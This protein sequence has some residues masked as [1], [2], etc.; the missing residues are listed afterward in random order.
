MNNDKKCKEQKCASTFGCVM[1]GLVSGVA[2]GAVGALLLSSN[3]KK[4]KK[5]ADKM[6]SAMS[7]LGESAMEMFK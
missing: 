5:K 7:E 6:M 4:L 2:V 3:K 1:A